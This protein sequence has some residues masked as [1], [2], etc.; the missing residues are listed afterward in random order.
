MF[1]LDELILGFS[2]SDLITLVLQANR[3]TKCA[4]HLRTLLDTEFPKL[5]RRAF[6][7]KNNNPC[8]RILGKVA[9]I[10]SFTL[11]KSDSAIDVVP[12]ILKVLEALTGISCSGVFFQCS[13]GG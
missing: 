6:F 1:V 11:L 12:G 10:S 8:D 5:S 4:S 7:S 2:Y 3:L 9:E 13:L